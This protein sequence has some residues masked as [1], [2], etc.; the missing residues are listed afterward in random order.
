MVGAFCPI[1]FP[2][3]QGS[4]FD[5]FLIDYFPLVLRCFSSFSSILDFQGSSGLTLAYF[6]GKMIPC[7]E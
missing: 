3:T 1:A 5:M 7:P 4:L 2:G 6:G